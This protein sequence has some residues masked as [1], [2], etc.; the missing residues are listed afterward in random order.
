MHTDPIETLPEELHPP[1]ARRWAMRSVG[2][3]LV[4]AG[5]ALLVGAALWWILPH[6]GLALPSTEGE[7]HLS[8]AVM[9][10]VSVAHGLA[11]VALVDPL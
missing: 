10:G 3:L 11:A 8:L 7:H 5:T 1:S 4:A 9:G 2:L 6:A